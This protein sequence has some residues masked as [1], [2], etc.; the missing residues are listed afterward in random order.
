MLFYGFNPM[1]YTM[2]RPMHKRIEELS[3]AE[4]F[5]SFKT[6]NNDYSDYIRLGVPENRI[7]SLKKSRLT[8]W[9]SIVLADFMKPRYLWTNK[10]I[11]ICHGVAAKKWTYVDAKGKQHVDDYRY[12]YSLKEYDFVF[13]HNEEDYRNAK[14][15]K[16]FKREDSGQIVGMCCLDEI[17]RNNNPEKINE[18]KI[19]YIAPEYREKK[20]VLYAPTWDETA[21]F[22]RKGE[23]ILDA[24]STMDCFLIM[25]PHPLCITSMV[26]TSGLDLVTFLKE[27]FPKKN[28][29]LITDTPY[30]IMPVADMMISDFSSISFEFTLLRKPLYLFEGNEIQQKIADNDQYEM[31]KKCCFVF[32]ETD[33]INRNIFK[34]EE[35][36]HD[37]IEEMENIQRKYFSNAGHAT[38]V[39]VNKLIERKIINPD[40]YGH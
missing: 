6:N 5:F 19:K 16:L 40:R 38:E 39:A 22:K 21:S 1:N 26:G 18:I 9:D 33:S 27:K 14:Q 15:R 11:Y 37:R 32:K 3:H 13:F 36:S 34:Y 4:V 17:I 23:E 31:L 12:N 2:F 8:I 10:L 24:L 35:L 7:L 29:L 25:K 30:E 20:V 28:Y